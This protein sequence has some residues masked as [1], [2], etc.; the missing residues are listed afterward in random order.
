MIEKI[1][2]FEDI[3][4]QFFISVE[5]TKRIIDLMGI[6]PAYIRV[7]KYYFSEAQVQLIIENNPRNYEREEFIIVKESKMNYESNR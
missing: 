2:S 3:E 6:I 1:Y 5:Q 4:N 7:K